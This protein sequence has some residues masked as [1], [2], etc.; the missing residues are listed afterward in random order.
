MS[1]GIRCMWMRGG[2][3][4]GAYFLAS[5]LPADTAQRDKQLLSIMGS[6]DPRQI[7]GI[8]GADPLT[9]KVAI[10][11]PSTRDDADLDYL[12][13]QVFVDKAVVTD[14]QGCGNILAGVA[15]FALERDLLPCD[16]DETVV[17]IHTLNSSELTEA[18]VCTPGRRVVYEGDA[19][20]AGVPGQHAPIPLLFQ[21]SA[22]SMSGS[23]LPTGNA[24]DTI[25]GVNVTM[26][27]N[28]MPCVILEAADVGIAGTESREDIDANI[29]LKERLEKLR[30]Q[31][32]PMMNLGDVTELS[33]PK[34][35]MVSRPL[36]GGVISTR[37]LIPHR[38]HATIGVMAAVTVA[39]A[40]LIPNSVASSLAVIPEQDLF[41]I[42][43]PSGVLQILI[44]RDTDNQVKA[45][46]TVRTARKLFDG[47]VF[48]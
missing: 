40:C 47:Q 18:R 24:V 10:V 46:G 5:D 33:V 34:M 38:V 48:P 1:D 39:T 21:G 13:L 43:H 42:E 12:F 14:A 29:E 41:D 45:A 44:S 23:L 3:S 7:D 30:L 8:G 35:T 27:D 25:D 32:G 31:A 2:S 9:S 6:P 16:E 17:R 15:P 22:G 4:K 36:H 28:G 19:E 26:I 11:S 20:I 37:S